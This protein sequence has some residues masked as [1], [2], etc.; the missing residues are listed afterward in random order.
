MLTAVICAKTIVV[1]A[2]VPKGI[3]KKINQEKWV[4]DWSGGQE[5]VVRPIAY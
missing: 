4:K 5:N 1:L 2:L 3:G